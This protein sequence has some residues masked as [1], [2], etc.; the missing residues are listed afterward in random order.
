VKLSIKLTPESQRKINALA[1]AGKLDLRP[2]M[3]VVG[4]GYRKEVGMIFDHEQP[5]GEKDRWAPLSDQYAAWK[6]KRFP[7]APILV[8]TGALR[9]S[10]TSEGAPGNIN[11]I[12][13]TGAVFGTSIPYGIYH[14]SDGQRKS[15]LPRRNFS[16]PS[17]RRRGIWMR[18]IED[19]IRKNFTDNG[20][21]VEG[22]IMA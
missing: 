22:G 3:N 2:T 5:R 21:N 17:D 6:A 16:E 1:K 7:G 9:R 12:G 14:D 11:T 20:I 19:N 15:K 18:Q 13:K 4:K 8:Q 10:M